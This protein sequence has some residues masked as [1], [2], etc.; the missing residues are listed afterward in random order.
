MKTNPAILSAIA[1]DTAIAIATDTDTA[2]RAAAS[3]SAGG[4]V[5]RLSVT[6]RCQ[7][8]CAYCLPERGHACAP[9]QHAPELPR[10]ALTRL[11]GLI[12]AIRPIRRVRFTGGEP[13]LR[14]DLP[15]LIGE[16]AALGI[17][18]L[19][20][21]TNGQ[22][23]AP[24]AAALRHAGVHRVNVSLDSLRPDVFAAISRGGSLGLTLA[25]IRAAR[26]AGLGPVKL[27]MVVLRGR[28][29]SEC[30]NLLRFALRSGCHIR[31]LELMPIGEA[32]RNFDRE[33]VPANEIRDR[34]EIPGLSWTELPWN[35]AETSRDWL[36]RDEDGRE[37]VCG[38][39]APTTQPFCQ[40]CARLRL[41]CDGRLHGCLARPS[42]H[43]LTPLL[44]LA[45]EAGARHQ[46]AE[47]FASAFSQKLGPRFDHAGPLMAAIGG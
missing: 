35:P 34:L 12:H 44:T 19:A 38:F 10:A 33:L 26:D 2:P 8:R 43:D 39:I 28:N 36:V 9:L 14:R 4:V 27:N 21:T 6:T 20:L 23:L 22:L 17:P 31:F 45:D 30:Q 46:L 1:T 5:V 24:R 15:E 40:G 25:G 41:T 11:L 29:D 37:T 18:E 13:L 47:I 42:E 7:F 3:A 32:A 16:T